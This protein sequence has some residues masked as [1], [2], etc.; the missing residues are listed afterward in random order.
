MKERRPCKQCGNP[1]PA[2]AVK[3]KHFCS[4]CYH[5]RRVE[6]GRKYRAEHKDELN[7]K[8]RQ[9]RAMDK[10]GIN[11]QERRYREGH[12]EKINERLRKRY[13]ETPERHREKSRRYYASHR[14]EKN[15][16]QRTRARERY[17]TTQ[18]DKKTRQLLAVM[19]K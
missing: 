17:R 15:D 5:A 12:K 6:K 19:A 2:G 7:E 4:K 11:E 13:K 9:D 16:K 18:R 8:K 3:Q 10:E 1:L 14:E